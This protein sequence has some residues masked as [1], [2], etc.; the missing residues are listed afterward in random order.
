M[1]LEKI[2]NDNIQKYAHKLGYDKDEKIL[3]AVKDYKNDLIKE[4]FL[5]KVI[6]KDITDK[7]VTDEYAKILENIN[8]KEERGI[9]HILVESEEEIRKIKTEL[10]N[11]NF[12]RI[13]KKNS[14]DVSTKNYGG[15]LGYVIKEDLVPEFGN[16]AFILKKGEISNPFK[17]KYGWHIIKVY[18]IKPLKIKPLDSSKEMIKK[19]LQQE[20]FEKF[21][22]E[23]TKKYKIKFKMK[24]KKIENEKK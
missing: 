20:K 21:L 15:D 12:E 2:I 23:E 14:I 8:G 1:I 9:K 22:I 6:Y 13:A 16:I 17:T 10:K 24:F 4:K 11:E 7:E 19:R 5:E 18:D 3:Q